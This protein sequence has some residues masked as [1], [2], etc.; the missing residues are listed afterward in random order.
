MDVA[1]VS[2][3]NLNWQH[4]AAALSLLA[5]MRFRYSSSLVRVAAFVAVFGVAK[6]CL[7][8]L[9]FDSKVAGSRMASS[10]LY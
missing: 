2:V 9:K 10:Q 8:R 3:S 1:Q 7:W 4:K 5:I 6:H